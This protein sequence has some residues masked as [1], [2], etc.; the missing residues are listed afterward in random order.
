MLRQYGPMILVGQYD[1]PY[2]RRVAVSL[3]A[4]GF[5]YEHDTRS[6]FGDFESMRQ[7]NPLVRIPSLVFDDGEVLIDSGAILDWLD[8]TV[9]P[10]RALIPRAGPERRRAR[11]ARARALAGRRLPEPVRDHDCLHA[12]L[13]PDGRPRAAPGGA[14]FHARCP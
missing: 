5:D 13:C 2:V 14:L 11:G 9:G 12:P 6:V 8:E 7:T 4:L 1:S 3:R 10:A